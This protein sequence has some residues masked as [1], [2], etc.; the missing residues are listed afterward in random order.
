MVKSVVMMGI[1]LNFLEPKFS[2]AV[3]MIKNIHTIILDL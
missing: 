2:T 1:T 3:Y